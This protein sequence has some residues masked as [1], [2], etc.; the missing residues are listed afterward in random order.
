MKFRGVARGSWGGTHDP[1]PA[2]W[3]A[4]PSGEERETRQTA[5]L[6]ISWYASTA[7]LRTATVSWVVSWASVAAVR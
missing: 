1:R 2:Y 7:L 4:R 3:P 5:I 6:M